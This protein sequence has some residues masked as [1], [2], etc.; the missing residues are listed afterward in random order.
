L[1]KLHDISLPLSAELPVWPGNEP[2]RLEKVHRLSAGGHCNESAYAANIHT[3]THIDVPWHFI[4]QG[5][6]TDALDLEV[7]MGPARVVHLPGVRRITAEVLQG[8]Q[9]PEDTAR[10][11]FR[12]DNS[13][14][15]SRGARAFSKDFVALTVDAAEWLAKTGLRL[16]GIDYLSI[17]LFGE[18]NR[19]HEALLEAGIVIVEGLNLHQVEAGDYE[20]ICLPLR[21]S[22]AEGAPARAVLRSLPEKGNH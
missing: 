13:L 14:L 10:L 6:K 11:L 3:G 18:S 15:W 12:T 4:E 9:L 1:T 7:M 16:V 19:T 17:Q 22:G 2:F 21:I 8:L 5:T 20:L